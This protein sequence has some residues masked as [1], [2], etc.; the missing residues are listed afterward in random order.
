MEALAEEPQ[1]ADMEG[2][3]VVHPRADPLHPQLRLTGRPR[4]ASAGVIEVQEAPSTS[5]SPE[6]DAL[7]GSYKVCALAVTCMKLRALS[8]MLWR[9]G[10]GQVHVGYGRCRQPSLYELP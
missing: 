5:G 10:R 4:C 1:D 9:R 3:G 6:D 8:S 7:S 2:N